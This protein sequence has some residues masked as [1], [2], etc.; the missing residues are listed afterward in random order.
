MAGEFY[1]PVGHQLG[2]A[3][4][5]PLGGFHGHELVAANRTANGVLGIG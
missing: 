4:G 2:A 5:E 1:A 3:I